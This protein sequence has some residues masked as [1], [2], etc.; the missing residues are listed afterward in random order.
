MHSVI[1]GADMH[2]G[3]PIIPMRL[4]PLPEFKP[5]EQPVIAHD[6]VRYVGEPIAV[7]LASSVAIGEDA[8]E[9]IEV[10]IED[11]PPVADWQTASANK[12]VL[13]E[14]QATNRSLVF[15]ARKGDA[16]AAFA[17]APLRPPRA[18][19]H[20]PPLRADHGAARRHGDVGRRRRQAHRSTAPPRCRSS[21]AASCR[22]RSACR[23]S[24]SR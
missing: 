2:G 21:T 6:K 8:L 20:R 16:D 10:E 15:Q 14:T 22:R 5:F 12:S 7:V 17:N 9:V 3:P 19:A 24:R 13:F 11:L 23:S 4:Q 18:P 1:T